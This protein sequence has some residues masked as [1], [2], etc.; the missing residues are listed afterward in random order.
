MQDLY[1]IGQ[2]LYIISPK[3]QT[4]V[5]VQ[6]Q[7]I[8]R[9][10]TIEG[11]EIH[12]LVMDPEGRGP[13]NLD[14][15]NGQIFTNP[16]DV[17]KTLKESANKAIDGMISKA[18]ELAKEKFGSNSTPSNDMFEKKSQAK[19]PPPPPPPKASSGLK[20]EPVDEDLSEVEVVDKNGKTHVQKQKVRIHM[21]K[22]ISA[23]S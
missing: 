6:V 7:E 17:G 13:H 2:I 23:V 18:T 14:E 9:R 15:I 20:P 11:E 1:K 22:E 3:T 10:T 16:S 12:F 5:P 19:T 8:N 21:P 4:V